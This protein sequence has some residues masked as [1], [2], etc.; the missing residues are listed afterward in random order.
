MHI[1]VLN[2][3]QIYAVRWL[4]KGEVIIRIVKLMLAILTLWKNKKIFMVW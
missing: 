2:I 4:S 3:L 1:D